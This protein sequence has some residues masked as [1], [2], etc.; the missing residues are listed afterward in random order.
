MDLCVFVSQLILP[1][2]CCI[3]QAFFLTSSHLRGFCGPSSIPM[4]RV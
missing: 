4:E 3:V 1:R 2:G